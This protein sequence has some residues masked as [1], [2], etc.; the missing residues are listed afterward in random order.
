MFKR[1]L[2]LLCSASWVA[3]LTAAPVWAQSAATPE[4]Q[5]KPKPAATKRVA[6]PSAGGQA[7]A[8]AVDEIVVTGFRA[9]LQSAQEQKRASDSI[10]DAV[11]AEDIG[12]LPDNNA[13]EVMSRIP[14]VQIT[15]NYD[16]GS[17]VLVRGLPNV[18]TTY[19]SREL[20]STDDRV[21]HW[22]D[23]PAS[24]AAG[25]EVYKT[26]TADLVEPGL[27]GLINLRS[28]RPFD[29]KD[30]TI[31]GEVKGTYNDQAKTVEPA[32][33]ILIAHTWDTSA[34]EIG[35]LLGA[36]YVRT[37]YH[38]A[39]RFDGASVITPSQGNATVTTPG[40]GQFRY[41]DYIG[42]Y[43]ATGKRERPAVNGMVQWRPTPDLELYVEGLWSGYRGTQANDFY[44]QS[45]RDGTL[46]NVVLVQGQD[47]K[48]ASLTHTGGN[49]P[50]VQRSALKDR[51][52]LYQGAFGFKW[53]TGRATVSGDFAYSKSRYVANQTRVD[54]TLTSTPTVNA[55]FEVAG[56]GVFDLNGY[57]MMNPDN[58]VLSGLYQ[59]YL[60]ASG[61][62]YQGRLDVDYDTNISWLTKLQAGF[63]AT[64]R[65]SVDYYGDR[66]AWIR[67]LN[68]PVASLPTGDLEVVRGAFRNDPQR[69]KNWLAPNGGAILDDS[70]A[71]RQLGYAGL[72]QVMAENS[73][74]GFLAGDTARYSTP[75]IQT[76]R[77]FYGKED[78]YAGYVQGK[79][80]FNVG[81]VHVDGTAGVR[82][83]YADGTNYGVE[84]DLVP[85]TADHE[86]LN[87]L[88]SIQSRIH[89]S[90]KLQLRLGY[91]ETIS[92]PG[93]GQLSPTAILSRATGVYT[94][95]ELT[96]GNPDLKPLKAK[97]YDASLEYYFSKHGSAS[98]AVFHKDLWGFID[99]YSHFETDPTNGTIRITRPENAGEGRINGAEASVQTFFDFLPGWLSGFG[100]QANLTYLDAK[101]AL[102]AALGEDAGLVPMANASKWT[103]NLVGFYEKGPISARISYNRRSHYVN[104]YY[105]NED[106]AQYAGE[107]VR[108][109]SRLDASIAYQINDK[110]SLVAT[111]SNL[112]AQPWK[113]Y[114]YYNETQYFPAD[115]RIEGRYV[116]L[117]FRFKM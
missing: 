97:N 34:G 90:D 96:T 14:G 49:A 35:A 87:V 117:G 25:F 107:L 56:S 89:L 11:V 26:A 71:L 54:A 112:L 66:Y 110:F 65:T 109:V 114:R 16:E 106:E 52:D 17:E 40:V 108:P 115:V 69:F 104:K 82:I 6:P 15:R 102:P 99:S 7:E 95:L 1:N 55:N 28:R 45:L 77:S 91:T 50:D 78:T 60:S 2:V 81:G 63:R 27:G 9:A 37:K 92:R 88:P 61:D 93:Y 24:V 100:A 38:Q 47:A 5:A 75:D 8:T 29:M 105:R 70:E 21:I 76:F 98:L 20:F 68:I 67:L 43:Y 39:L 3:M 18:A 57:D 86:W 74:A 4:Q 64:T 59:T 32:G 12:K 51:T 101:S 85:A 10:V 22:Q 83:A 73:W 23:L 113:D 103:Y 44:G 41:P 80:Q 94:G 62:G 42:N 36:S 116:S 46:S 33:N 19:N 30:A 79:Y 13:A 53:T 72:Q 84:S 31:A 111:G 58:Y 48:A